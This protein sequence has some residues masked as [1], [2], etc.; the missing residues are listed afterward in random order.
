MISYV[1]LYGLTLP[2]SHKNDLSFSDIIIFYALSFMHFQL[3]RP[4]LG[5]GIKNDLNYKESSV[6]D[7]HI[8]LCK[9]GFT[10]SKS[11]TDDFRFLSLIIL[12][13]QN[14]IPDCILSSIASGRRSERVWNNNSPGSLLR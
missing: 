14:L 4:V 7:F 12:N 9:L 2:K 11:H 8:E 10:H 1:N 13:S 6:W 3:L 5:F